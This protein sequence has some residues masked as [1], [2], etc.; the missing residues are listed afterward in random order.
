MP[1]YNRRASNELAASIRLDQL[2]ELQ[3][4]LGKLIQD[5]NP[6]G[7]RNMAWTNLLVSKFMSAGWNI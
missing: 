2:R 3:A 7:M 5:A 6:A 1:S 4:Q